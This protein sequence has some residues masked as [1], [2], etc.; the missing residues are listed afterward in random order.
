VIH[1]NI[2]GNKHIFIT[3]DASSCLDVALYNSAFSSIFDSLKEN[4]IFLLPNQ[5]E[6]KYDSDKLKI[7][8]GGGYK[9]TFKVNNSFRSYAYN[10]I[11]QYAETYPTIKEFKEFEN[12]VEYMNRLIR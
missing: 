7:Y 11:K 2:T 12:I 8:D 5:N 10:N 1:G 4:E 9:L 3:Y 6:L